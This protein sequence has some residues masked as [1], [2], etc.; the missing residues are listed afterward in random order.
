MHSYQCSAL[1]LDE[2]PSP[3]SKFPSSHSSPDHPVDSH[4]AVRGHARLVSRVHGLMSHAVLVTE[5]AGGAGRPQSSHSESELP[6]VAEHVPDAPICPV[7]MIQPCG[8][9]W[10]LEQ[11]AP[12]VE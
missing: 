8:Q 12:M 11:S 10:Q 3:F 9:L 6:Q 2:H 4:A 7:P 1:H 5:I